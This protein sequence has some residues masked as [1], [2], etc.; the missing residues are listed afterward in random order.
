MYKSNEITPAMVRELYPWLN[1]NN[2]QM[3]I[4]N[5]LDG[6]LTGMFFFHYLGWEVVGVYD[7]EKI[8]LADDF[9]GTLNDVIFVDLDVTYKQYKSLGHHIVAKESHNHLNINVLFGI[10]ENKY[11]SKFPLSTAL[12]LYWLYE[13]ELPIKP[14][15]LLFLLHADSTWK[16][17]IDYTAN[18][19]NWLNRLD[20]GNLIYF[21][22][23]SNFRENIEKYVLPNTYDWNNQCGY[24]IRNG[25]AY[26]KQSNKDF[27]DY[28]N[29]IA[30][31]FGFNPMQMPN[32]LNR[33]KTFNRVQVDI[34]N[35]SFP[36]VLSRLKEE[37]EVFS[38]SLKYRN[39]L[40]V[41]YI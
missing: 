25:K 39:K 27:Q 15:P 12:F 24:Y 18:V 20:M 32:N 28:L 8:Y 30:Q 6:I 34:Y 2:Q 31:V 17:H 38:Y 36:D 22:K 23:G 4:H 21:M 10:D 3:I 40:D 13:K 33:S 7:L 1:Q 37:K 19:E 29:C 35:R 26:F 9:K 5:D 11:T 14:L 16:N 41:S